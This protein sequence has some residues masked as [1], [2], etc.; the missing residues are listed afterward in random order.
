VVDKKTTLAT[1]PGDPTTDQSADSGQTA[2]AA[3]ACAGAVA[4]LTSP[5]QQRRKTRFR[6]R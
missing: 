4:A 6:W 3:N 2:T 5:D 1:H